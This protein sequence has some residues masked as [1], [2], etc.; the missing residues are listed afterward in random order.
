MHGVTAFIDGM[1]EAFGKDAI[2][3]QIRLG[4]AGHGTFWASENGIEIGSR[5]RD[6]NNREQA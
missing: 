4:I 2:D 3:A 1:R 5:P 6:N